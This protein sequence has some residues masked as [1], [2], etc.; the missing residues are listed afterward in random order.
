MDEPLAPGGRSMQTVEV[1]ACLLRA[2]ARASDDDVRAVARLAP[3]L[4]SVP[5]P[6]CTCFALRNQNNGTITRSPALSRNKIRKCGIVL[7]S[8]AHN[9]EYIAI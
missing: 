5:G 6:G 2:G 4:G 8:M 1:A 9:V 3:M 7:V